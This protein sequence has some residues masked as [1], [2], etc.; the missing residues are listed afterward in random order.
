MRLFGVENSRIKSLVLNTLEKKAR[1]ERE[2]RCF[3][4]KMRAQRGERERH[5]SCSDTETDNVWDLDG[6]VVCRVQMLIEVVGQLNMLIPP[7][8]Q[9]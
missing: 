3:D 1:K 9:R 2:G 4:S 8:I 7:D 6:G 5:S